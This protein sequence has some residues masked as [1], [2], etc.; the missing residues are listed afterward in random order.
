MSGRVAV[1]GEL[2]CPG[3]ELNQ[4]LSAILRNAEAAEVFLQDASPDL[5]KL[6]AIL[7]TCG[8]QR[9]GAVIDRMREL[10][11]HRE[12]QSTSLD[13]NALV[14]EVASL[15]RLD[16]QTRQVV[17][18]VEPGT[19]P[20]PVLGDRIQ[21]QQVLL[22]LF[23][24]AMDA[25]ADC[26]LAAKRLVVR[27]NAVDGDVE[28]A[29]RDSG[30]GISAESLKRIF[31]PFFTTKANGLGIGLA[32]SRTITTAHGGR[33]LAENN[34]DGGATFRLRLPAAKEG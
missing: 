26:P 17:L 27:V 6:R 20:P 34:A 12:F 22:N 1:M 29:V 18:V 33:I 7:R 8:D 23:L 21:L 11:K 16:A 32:I 13:L 5:E 10:L 30:H 25:M 9:A 4:P 24:N 31:E 2:A 15:V 3:H 28:V 14:A 19:A